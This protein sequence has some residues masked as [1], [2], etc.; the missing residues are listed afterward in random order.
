[1]KNAIKLRYVLKSVFNLIES[2]YKYLIFLF[3]NEFTSQIEIFDMAKNVNA[4][5][6][7]FSPDIMAGPLKWKNSESGTTPL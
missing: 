6:Y 4:N 5:I 2:R 3:V 1:M 7:M